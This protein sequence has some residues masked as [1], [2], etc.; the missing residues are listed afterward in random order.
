MSA[1]LSMCLFSKKNKMS[2]FTSRF[3]KTLITRS[4]ESFYY[5]REQTMK[6]NNMYIILP[7]KQHLYMPLCSGR[8]SRETRFKDLNHP[9]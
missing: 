3:I 2:P 4:M 8:V 5:S 9:L 7:L 6:G 1:D